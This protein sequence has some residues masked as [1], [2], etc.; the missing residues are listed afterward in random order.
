MSD[1]QVTKWAF[2]W[3]TPPH[4]TPLQVHSFARISHRTQEK[5]FIYRA[6]IKTLAQEQPHGRGVGLLCPLWAPHLP[7]RSS[8]NPSFKGLYGGS[9][10]QLIK[11]LATFHQ[12]AVS[13]SRTHLELGSRQDVEPASTMSWGV[14]ARAFVCSGGSCPLPR[15]LLCAQP[16]SGNPDRRQCVRAH[17]RPEALKWPQWYFQPRKCLIRPK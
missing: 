13:L 2:L 12:V 8:L 9:I 4:P 3:P 16:P 6:I 17:A 1:P 10:R 5:T 14:P 7:A 11:L 15:F